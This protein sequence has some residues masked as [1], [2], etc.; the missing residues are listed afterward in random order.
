MGLVDQERNSQLLQGGIFL[1]PVQDFANLLNR[2][3]DDRLA[4]LKEARQV[5]GLPSNA[6]DVLQVRELLNVV[7]DVRVQGLA[8]REDEHDIDQLLAAARL[9]QAVQT[10]SQPADRERLAAARRVV[11]QILA[12]DV[13]L[14]R[15]VG[16]DVLGQLP[17]HAALMVARV[18]RVR[19]AGGL[20]FLHF[21]R[22]DVQ[23]EE[24]QRLQ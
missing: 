12:A 14:F 20:V 15:E 17:H 3:D 18:N 4:L 5:V 6:H 11:D 8:V 7:A 10:L 22:R 13:P 24:R 9:V 2:R 1:Q 16:R 23:Q 19:R 21:A